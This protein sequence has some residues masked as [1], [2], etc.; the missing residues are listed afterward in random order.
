MLFKFDSWPGVLLL[1]YVVDAMGSFLFTSLIVWRSF[2]R[3]NG[4]LF[5]KFKVATIIIFIDCTRARE[6]PLLRDLTKS[7]KEGTARAN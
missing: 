6:L 7:T 4:Q 2:A 3:A 1:M 5:V